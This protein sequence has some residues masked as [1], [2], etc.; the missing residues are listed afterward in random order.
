MS[1]QCSIWT[2]DRLLRALVQNP[3]KVHKVILGE[4]KLVWSALQ[5][6]RKIFFTENETWNPMTI[7]NA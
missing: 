5:Q 2:Q 4:K 1:N 3:A 7:S 6:N